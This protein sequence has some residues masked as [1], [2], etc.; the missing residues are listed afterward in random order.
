[1]ITLIGANPIEVVQGE[2]YTELGATTT[3]NVD[4]AGSATASGTVDTDTVGSY[5]ITYT[6]TDAAGNEA[7]AV[8]RTVNVT[9]APDVH[10]SSDYTNWR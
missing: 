1:M 10:S 4:A 9:A 6:A 5:T 2:A 8:T 3:D 7:V